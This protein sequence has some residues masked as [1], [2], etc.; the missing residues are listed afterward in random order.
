MLAFAGR[1]GETRG[2]GE[3][4]RVGRIVGALWKAILAGWGVG[5]GG[6]GLHPHP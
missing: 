6:Q 4:A 1:E 2:V 5:R 3:E